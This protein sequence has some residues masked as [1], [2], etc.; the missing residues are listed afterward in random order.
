MGCCFYWF[1]CDWCVQTCLLF[2]TL[3]ILVVCRLAGNRVGIWQISC[4]SGC[5]RWWTE[6]NGTSSNSSSCLNVFGDECLGVLEIDQEIWMLMDV[7]CDFGIGCWF[8]AHDVGCSWNG[9]LYRMLDDD[10]DEWMWIG[11]MEVVLLPEGS[12][13][14]DYVFA[15]KSCA[16]LNLVCS[17]WYF[18]TVS[19]ATWQ[20]NSWR[21]GSLVSMVVG[22]EK[23]ERS[24]IV[25]VYSNA[26]KEKENISFEV[27]QS[28]SV[29]RKT[30]E[31]RYCCGF[32]IWEI[33]LGL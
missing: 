9:D 28:F 29:I 26:K 27:S 20:S 8:L 17:S 10:V 25:E 7:G 32:P 33:R 15:T 3:I 19:W 18:L 6:W 30:Q 22:K 4:C 5:V 14:E 24:K 11:R 23:E 21:T 13:L 12:C 2:N 31:Y 1:G 16:S